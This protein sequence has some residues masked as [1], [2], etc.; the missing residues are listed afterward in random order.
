MEFMEFCIELGYLINILQVCMSYYYFL[1]GMRL[2]YLS[3][4]LHS[5]FIRVLCIF[6]Y[7]SVVFFY[8]RPSAS[9]LYLRQS[10]SLLNLRKSASLLYSRAFAS[11]LN[12]RKSASLS[13]LRAFASITVTSKEYNLLSEARRISYCVQ[14]SSSANYRFSDTRIPSRNLLQL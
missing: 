6:A 10:A 14:L 12:L 8:S 3:L 9:L 4:T 5:R 2:L 1:H 13:Y 7:I 11:L